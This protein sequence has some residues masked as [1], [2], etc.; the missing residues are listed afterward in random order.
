M[1]NFFRDNRVNFLF[2][3]IS[4]ICMT[5]VVGF[6][7]IHFQN[8][9]WLYAGE[10]AMHQLGW[11]FFKNDV[12]RFPVIGENPN[13]GLNNGSTIAFSSMIPFLALIFK[14]LKYF[15]PSS[16]NYYGFWFFLCFYLQ[17]YVSFLLIKKLTNDHYY[18]LVG[19]IF[20]CLS[21]IFFNQI[22][23]HF[24]LSGQWIIILSFYFYCNDS[25]DKKF[26]YNI[27][28]ICFSTLVHFYFTMML[29][30][31]YGVLA[32]FNFIDKKIFYFI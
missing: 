32:F 31:I 18:S 21:P 3:L 23:I 14:S 28:L 24:S 30:I 19:S 27:F 15:I 9:E 2:L 12:W 11:H 7:N 26:S 6:H 10:P 22:G 1:I 25:L 20:F 8:T 5:C 17:S 29:S 13:Y 4:F 16:F